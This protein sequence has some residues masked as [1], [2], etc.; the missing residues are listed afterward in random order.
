MSRLKRRAS[1]FGLGVLTAGFVLAGCSKPPTQEVTAAQAV[2]DS[3]KAVPD[4]QTYAMDQVQAAE[5]A[6]AAV[7]QQVTEKKYD[8]ARAALPNV[9]ETARG[10]VA[11]AATAKA[12]AMQAA[13]SAIAEAK[14]AVGAAQGKVA[15]ARPR[16]KAAL[17]QSITAAN[18]L[19]AEAEA[20]L[21][22][23]DLPMATAKAREAS[24]K[25]TQP[26]P[27]APA[28]PPAR[29]HAPARRPAPARSK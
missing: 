26:A 3:V 5:Q 13:G 7:R 15:K 28:A 29:R 24:V 4:V 22:N 9:M 1:L 20:C 14:Q 16:E 11:V 25:A 27:A 8:E 12:A 18:A 17:Q 23:N 10:A 2:I 6:L 21:R 19:V